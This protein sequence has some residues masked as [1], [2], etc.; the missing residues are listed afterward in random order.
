MSYGNRYP[1]ARP[2]LGTALILVFFLGLMGIL[3]WRLWPAPQGQLDPDVTPRPVVA[4]GELGA[5][6]QAII[7]LFKQSAPSVVHITNLT[8]HRDFFSVDV[9]K[10]PRGTGSG[11]VWD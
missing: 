6:E 2:V 10:I 7:K 5:D 1:A 8:V 4:R 3:I 11:I 9:M